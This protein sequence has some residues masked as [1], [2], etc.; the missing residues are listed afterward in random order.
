LLDQ[1][2]AVKQA[3]P[4]RV[5]RAIWHADRS[6]YC[7]YI[8]EAVANIVTALE[9]L[10]N[11]DEDQQIVAQFVKRSQRLAAEVGVDTSRSYWDWVYDVRSKAVH[12]AE[13]KLVVPA[14]WDQTPSDPPHD[15]ARVARAQDVLRLAL[16]KAIED[17]AFRAVFES[18]A[19]IRAQFPLDAPAQA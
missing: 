5:Q 4:D 19:S 14:G 2:R 12:G 17:E 6:C 15:V 16:Q 18:E 8:H 10:L 9:A 3:L 1:Y 7:P 13:A 11:T